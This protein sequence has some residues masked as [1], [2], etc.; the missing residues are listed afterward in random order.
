ME[1]TKAVLEIRAIPPAIT[2]AGADA[3]TKVMQ[4]AKGQLER[5]IAE[6]AKYIAN[7]NRG[8]K[9]GKSGG[10]LKSFVADGMS[11]ESAKKKI[12]EKWELKTP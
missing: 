10:I 5:A 6:L 1:A 11:K 7:P 8:F 4:E 3:E 9:D 2:E 12:L